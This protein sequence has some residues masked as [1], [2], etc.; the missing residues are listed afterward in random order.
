MSRVCARRRSLKPGHMLQQTF[1]KF[2]NV[3]R[4]TS[5]VFIAVGL[6]T[7][8]AW[9]ATVATALSL[10]E[11][12]NAGNGMSYSDAIIGVII[13]RALL[14]SDAPERVAFLSRTRAIAGPFKHAPRSKWP[15]CALQLEHRN[16]SQ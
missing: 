1:T 3:S 11:S 7:T 8:L 10:N 16:H 12:D 13:T 15:I 4:V 14:Y 9:L 6:A 2:V 5:A